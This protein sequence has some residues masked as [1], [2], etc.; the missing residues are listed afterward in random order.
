ML[1]E[2]ALTATTRT[3]ANVLNVKLSMMKAF[4]LNAPNALSTID[5][6]QFQRS[7][8][9]AILTVNAILV[10]PMPVLNVLMVRGYP[11]VSVLHVPILFLI[12]ID[13]RMEI[14]VKFVMRILLVSNLDNATNVNTDGLKLK[15]YKDSTLAK[16]VSVKIL[17]VSK[18]L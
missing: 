17:T 7:V 1:L 15:D 4:R 11:T 13:A 9:F 16:T 10:L 18:D 12:V 5:L 2:T 3:I 14:L 8:N 6:T